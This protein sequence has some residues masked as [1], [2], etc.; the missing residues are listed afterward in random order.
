MESALKKL[1]AVY[2]DFFGDIQASEL[3]DLD[4]LKRR[5]SCTEA[6]V[7]AMIGSE[8]ISVESNNAKDLRRKL[9]RKQ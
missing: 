1:N 8:P 4:E 9:V 2:G 5:L 3:D 7:A 6:G